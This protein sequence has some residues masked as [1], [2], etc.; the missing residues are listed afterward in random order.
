MEDQLRIKD[1]VI[2]E[3][4]N[5]DNKTLISD[6]MHK[7]QIEDMGVCEQVIGSASGVAPA[8]PGY[9]G[10]IFGEVEVDTETGE[11]KVLKLTSA[12]DVGR[13]INPD[14]VEGQIIGECG[15][16]HIQCNLSCDRRKVDR[17][18]YDT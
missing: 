4:K 2:F 18:V 6:L 9:Y 1:A 5:P 13:A 8:M 3:A 14:L 10:A 11:V 15:I 16:G 17:P 12:F 7:T